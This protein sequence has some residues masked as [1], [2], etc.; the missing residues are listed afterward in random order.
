MTDIFISFKNTQ[1]G[2]KTQDSVFADTLYK[3]LAEDM[4][5]NVFMMNETLTQTG[6]ANYK[7]AIDIALSEARC[8]IA[9]GSKTDYL[10]SEWVRYEWDTYLCEILAGRKEDNVFTVRLNDMQIS[11]LP[12]GL[13]KYQSFDLEQLNA[14][15]AYVDNCL[16]PSKE[17]REQVSAFVYPAVFNKTADGYEVFFP[18]LDLKTDGEIIEMA[19]LFAVESLKVYFTYMIKYKLDYNLPSDFEEIRNN[20][21]NACSVMLITAEIIDNCSKDKDNN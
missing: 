21:P 3:S 9:I 18:D 19:Y 12:I 16:S 10:E 5:Y 4:H 13:R 8:L 1:N 11:D 2:E 7:K 20:Y 6:D 15:I 17:E 14:L